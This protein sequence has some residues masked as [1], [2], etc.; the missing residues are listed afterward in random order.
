MQ[1]YKKMLTNQNLL[2]FTGTSW[3]SLGYYRGIKQYDY[4]YNTSKYKE[5]ETYLY[6]DKI[7]YGL[8]GVI[9]YANVV[10]LPF[11]IYKEIYRLEVKLRGIEYEKNTEKYN[12]IF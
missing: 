6:S 10:F 1:F 8:F 11:T 5:Y 2:F 4:K 12:T 9:V 7:Y 3:L